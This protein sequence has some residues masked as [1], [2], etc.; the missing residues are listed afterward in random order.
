MDQA[1]IDRPMME[2]YS[3]GELDREEIADRL[4]RNVSVADLILTLHAANLPLP[5]YPSS[6]PQKD[7]DWLF[8]WLS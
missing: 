4:D 1:I 5:H 3:R 7:Q 6:L 8:R 2:A